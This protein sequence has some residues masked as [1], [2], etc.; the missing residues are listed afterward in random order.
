MKGSYLPGKALLWF[1][2]LYNATAGILLIASG[3]LAIRFA[4]LILGWT[5]EGSPALGIAGEILGCQLL[6]F[7]LMLF[8]ITLDPMRYRVFLNVAI[9]F[10]LLRLAQRVYF[11]DK[12]I[13]TF[14]VPEARYWGSCVFVA[15]LAAAL[16]AFRSQLGRAAAGQ[17]SA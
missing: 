4:S 10:V 14:H 9:A 12:I 8:V 3:E 5:V 7:A 6:A 17:R 15:L 16:F 13:E 1:M 2:I 11:S